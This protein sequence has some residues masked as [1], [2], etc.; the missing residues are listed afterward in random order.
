MKEIIENEELKQ[1]QITIIGA[2]GIGSHLIGNLIP[3]LH[4]GSLWEQ[5]RITV[6]V[7]DSDIVSIENTAHQMATLRNERRIPANSN[8]T[9]SGMNRNMATL[10]ASRIP[11]PR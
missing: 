9:S 5:A 3:V 6:R 10:I 4:R 8:S 7:Y 2:G 1:Y 11:P